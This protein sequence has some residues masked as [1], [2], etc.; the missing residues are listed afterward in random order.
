[1][2][3]YMEYPVHTPDSNPYITPQ[4]HLPAS[5]V[6]EHSISAHGYG[7]C[8]ME[9]QARLHHDAIVTSQN[10]GSPTRSSPEN[11][12]IAPGCISLPNENIPY[13]YT[14]GLSYTGASPY[15]PQPG[16]TTANTTYPSGQQYHTNDTYHS[17]NPLYPG[18]FPNTPMYQQYNP[19][20]LAANGGHEDDSAMNSCRIRD[21]I[22]PSTSVF[23]SRSPATCQ[24]NEAT[25]GN[26]YDWMKI[27]RNPP[28][29]IYYAQNKMA[30]Y[31]YGSSG[32]GRT[33]FTTKQLTELEKE[34]HFNKY[35]TRARRVEIAA[36]LHLNETQV[37]IWFQNR[38]MKQ[39]KRDKE[40]EK[41]NEKK[42]SMSKTYSNDNRKSPQMTSLPSTPSTQ[43]DVTNYNT[44]MSF[45]HQFQKSDVKSEMST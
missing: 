25:T 38:R 15:Y 13:P 10:D 29:S 11:S 33:N 28:K 40:A 5:P 35:L 2:N 39:K 24:T 37:K 21:R 4:R 8:S 34:F 6:I 9:E 31:S 20:L 30:D 12:P 7:V 16:V 27:K 32:N 26:T 17:T 42:I 14:T 22:S 36:A 43:C 41:F 44:V 1:M 3:S 19:C 18:T 45:K 23:D